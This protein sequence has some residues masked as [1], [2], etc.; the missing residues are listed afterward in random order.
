MPK[1]APPY[2]PVAL[3]L[4][5]PCG[6]MFSWI[7]KFARYVAALRSSDVVVSI[8]TRRSHGLGSKGSSS[9]ACAQRRTVDRVSDIGRSRFNRAFGDRG[10]TCGH[11]RVFQ[12]RSD[13]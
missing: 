12:S 3:H 5:S 11:I 10:A 1:G 6:T 13:G 4:I 2:I 8:K 7:F 9:N